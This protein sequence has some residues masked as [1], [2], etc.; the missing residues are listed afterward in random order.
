MR[1]DATFSE[2]RQS[3]DKYQDSLDYLHA[4]RRERLFIPR[5]GK[6]FALQIFFSMQTTTTIRAQTAER[7]R[8]TVER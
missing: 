3:I 5:S 1:R 6:A 4:H 2:R 8:E 7:S